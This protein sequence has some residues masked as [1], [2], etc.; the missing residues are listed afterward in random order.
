MTDYQFRL[1]RV[2]WACSVA[3]ERHSN[4]NIYCFSS[5]LQIFISDCRLRLETVL[6]RVRDIAR[7]LVKIN[8]E[9]SS[10]RQ[11]KLGAK[12]ENT[13]RREKHW[14]LCYGKL[15]LLFVTMTLLNN[16]IMYFK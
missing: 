3:A 12:L 1:Q 15:L 6:V 9:M 16:N 13:K 5:I 10:S 11:Q 8:L 7:A 4:S 2:L 14:N